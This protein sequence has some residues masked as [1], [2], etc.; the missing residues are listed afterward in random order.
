MDPKKSWQFIRLDKLGS[1][2]DGMTFHD[3]ALSVGA[4]VK[5]R[6]FFAQNHVGFDVEVRVT[7]RRRLPHV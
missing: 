1:W 7:S 2:N 5:A 6:F 3:I 4:E